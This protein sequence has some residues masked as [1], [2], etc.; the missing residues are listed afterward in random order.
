[1][2]FASPPPSRELRGLV[3]SPGAAAADAAAR[4]ERLPGAPARR[5]LVRDLVQGRS[6]ESGS[7]SPSVRGIKGG[8]GGAAGFQLHED[9]L[10][11]D[12][13]EEVRVQIRCR[14][15]RSGI[16]LNIHRLHQG[17]GMMSAAAWAKPKALHWA[18]APKAPGGVGGA[19]LDE[20]IEAG[21]GATA[22]GAR[23]RGARYRWH[24]EGSRAAIDVGADPG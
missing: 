11:E 2:D 21:Q 5:Q 6:A 9:D 7:S 3:P 10:Q 13:D 24:Q 8:V 19:L 17:D 23:V 4:R 1:M 20:C 12:C 14:L 18:G 16:Q 15:L 22:R